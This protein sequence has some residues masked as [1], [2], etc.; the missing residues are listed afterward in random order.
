MVWRQFWPAT[1]LRN[2]LTRSRLW[3]ARLWTLLSN[4][5]LGVLLSL[6]VREET[7]RERLSWLAV[8]IQPLITL[9]VYKKSY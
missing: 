8:L 1:S 6:S 9:F 5:S 4:G 3:L 7:L 2:V